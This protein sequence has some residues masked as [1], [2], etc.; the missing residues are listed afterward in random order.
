VP[1]VHG[2]GRV[3]SKY[4][5]GEHFSGLKFFSQFTF[6]FFHLDNIPGF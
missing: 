6:N 3:V 1:L 2:Q 5:D 4:G